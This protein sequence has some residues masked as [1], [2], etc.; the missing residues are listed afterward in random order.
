MLHL[1]TCVLV[2]L[3]A[4]RAA[5]PICS[6]RP[7]VTALKNCCKLP[8]LDLSSFNSKCSQY[9]INGAHIS[10]CSF[11]CFFQAAKALNGTQLDLD[12]IEKM[13]KTILKSDEFVHVYVDG[14]RSC[15]TQEQALIKTLKRRRVS[16]TGKCGS[17]AIMYGLCAHRYVYRNCPD[18]A[19]SKSPSCNEAREYN[20]RCDDL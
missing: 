7:D 3:P 17:M 18:R 9:L 1:L 14:F 20:I 10:P 11:E 4:Y 2:F 13:M 12:N 19:W 15:S 16:I 6:K 8:S 5:D